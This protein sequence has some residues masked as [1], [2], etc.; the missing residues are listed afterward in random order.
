MLDETDRERRQ[1]DTETRKHERISEELVQGLRNEY[2][3]R[4]RTLKEE[5]RAVSADLRTLIEDKNKEMSRVKNDLYEE[6]AKIK[7][8]RNVLLDSLTKD[9]YVTELN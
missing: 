3:D 1:H 7:E 6:E 4:I 2:E 5:H 9:K 8:Q